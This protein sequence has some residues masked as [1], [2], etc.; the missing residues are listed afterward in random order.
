MKSNST[1]KFEEELVWILSHIQGSNQQKKMIIYVR[2]INTCYNMFLWLV[3]AIGEDFFIHGTPALQNRR[4]EM[5]HANTDEASKTRIL[6][7]FS[8]QSGSIQVL[9]STVAFGMG[10]NLPDVDI[11]IHW[12]LPNSSLSYW[13]EVG[14]CARDGRPG[15]A[16]CYAFKRSITKCTDESLKHLVKLESCSRCIVLKNFLLEGMGLQDM[17]IL[18]QDIPCSG[19]CEEQC[20]C[21]NCK[22][23]EVCYSQCKCPRKVMNSLQS[24]LK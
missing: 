20:M 6:E 7:D 15:Y 23:C 1:E 4:V 24:F 9:I 14:R 21:K 18:L 2:S 5:F 16:I 19:D 3:S 12:G 11:V 8:K 17:D 13:Q 10:I 22:C